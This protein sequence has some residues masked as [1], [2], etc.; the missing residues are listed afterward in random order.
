MV[1]PLLDAPNRISCPV[2]V[3]PPPL[4]RP[5]R[6][7]I[8]KVRVNPQE[9]KRAKGDTDAQN[10]GLRFEERVQSQLIMGWPGYHPSP[11]LHFYDGEG[12][13]TLQPDGVYIDLHRIWIVEIKSQHM[14]EAWWQ[15][16]QLYRPV[17]QAL[18]KDRPVSC[19][20]IVKSFDPIMP[21]PAKFD[22]VDKKDLFN[23]DGPFGVCKW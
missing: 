2:S 10:A 4:F 13:R 11:Y 1:R 12:A 9:Y 16:D 7:P 18:Y 14:P 5:L 20:E 22:M 6:P 19:L 23:Y 15:L 21:F 8:H 17:I 3:P